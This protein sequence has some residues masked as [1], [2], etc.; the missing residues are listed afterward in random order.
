MPVEAK[1]CVEHRNLMSEKDSRY[2]SIFTILFS[3]KI[4]F[5]KSQKPYLN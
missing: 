4:I 2:N 3:L 5:E 1:D